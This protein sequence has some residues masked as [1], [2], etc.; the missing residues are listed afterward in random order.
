MFNVAWSSNTPSVATVNSSG[1]VTGVDPGSAKIKAQFPLI[2][3]LIGPICGANPVCPGGSPAPTAPVTVFDF[4]VNL[5]PST[6]RPRDTGGVIETTT[7]TVQTNP[8]L[9]GL[10]FVFKDQRL[11]STASGH[12]QPSVIRDSDCRPRE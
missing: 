8:P 1:V 9:N 10:S 11:T 2:V 4:T 3:F 12:Q 6:I 5:S 7:V